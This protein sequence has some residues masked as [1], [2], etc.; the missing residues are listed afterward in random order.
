V[1]YRSFAYITPKGWEIKKISNKEKRI[2]LR[3]KKEE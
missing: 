3:R 2:Y 1:K